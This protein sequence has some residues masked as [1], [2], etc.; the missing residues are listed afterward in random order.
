[1]N[2]A[3]PDGRAPFVLVRSNEGKPP[4]RTRRLGVL[5]G[6][7]GTVKITD[8]GISRAVGDVT[9]TRT[10]MLAGTLAYFAPELARGADPTPAADVFSLGA[11]RPVGRACLPTGKTSAPQRD[12]EVDGLEGNRV[13]VT[14]VVH[15]LGH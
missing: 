10:G 11:T 8:F 15:L 3:R 13:A 6:H 1:M 2:G 4:L 12:L 9:V 7:D 14:R 5:I